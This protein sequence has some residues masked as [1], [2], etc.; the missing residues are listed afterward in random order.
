MK[1]TTEKTLRKIIKEQLTNLA[2]EAKKLNEQGEIDLNLD[3]T[4]LQGVPKNLQKLLDPDASP[5]KFAALDA[6][7]DEKGS[8]QHQAFALLAFAMN[9]ADKDVKGAVSLLKKA[10]SLAPNVQKMMDKSKK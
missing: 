4:K 5:Q 9:Y 6:E 3:V 8:P 2:K 10:Q 1:I 7:L